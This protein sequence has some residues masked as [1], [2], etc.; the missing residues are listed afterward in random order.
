M[1]QNFIIIPVPKKTPIICYN[2]YR[3]VA[4][5]SIIM[6][7][8]ERLVMTH[9]KTIISPTLNPLQ[10]A[11]RQNHSTADV[12]SHVIHLTLSHLEHKNTYVRMFF[13]LISVLHLILFCH[14]HSSENFMHL[15]LTPHFTTESWIS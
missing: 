11:Y 13:L 9:I 12:I 6:K 3:P 7:C 14:R 10:F 4:L 2:D 8:L 5:T 1:P 15:N